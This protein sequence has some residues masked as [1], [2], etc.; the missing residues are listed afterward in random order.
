LYMRKYSRHLRIGTRII[1]VTVMCAVLFLKANAAF[2]GSSDLYF[3]PTIGKWETVSHDEIGWK[4]AKLKIAMDYAG[5]QNSSGVVILYRGRILAEQYWEIKSAAKRSCYKN[6]LVETTSDGRAIEEV[7]S[8]QKSVISFLA[9]I[10]REQ[11]K[12]DLDRTVASYIGDGWSKASPEKEE[13]I[14][15]RHLMTMTSGLNEALKYMHPAGTVWKYN[16]KPYSMMVP[17]L[18]KATNMDIDQL[19]HQWL[20]SPVGMRESRWE[21]RRWVQNHHAANTIGFATSARDLARFGLLVLA[22]GEWNGHAVLKNSKYLFESLQPSQ[23]LKSSYGLLWWL[24]N[25]SW[26]PEAPDK[27]VAALGRLSRIVFIVPDKQLVI[28]RLGD[29][30][31]PKNPIFLHK[32]WKLISAAMPD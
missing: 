11:G 16:T 10:A 6:M 29:Q 9:A 31:N 17:V 7:A 15:V 19:T 12:L 22:E 28:I 26:F 20:T 14:T 30:T 3:P 5:Q 27:A 25:R 21:S 18:T 32:F 23:N 8:V 2:A 1:N 4:P 13:R 24:V